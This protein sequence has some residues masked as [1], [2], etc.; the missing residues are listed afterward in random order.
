MSCH[1]KIN[2]IRMNLNSIKQ[3][4]NEVANEKL[5]L[6]ST[7]TA[8]PNARSKQDG[9]NKSD[10]E[11]YKVRYVYT[12]DNFLSQKGETRDFCK[13][14][15]SAKKIYRKEDIIQMTNKIY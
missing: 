3:V 10:N 12:K 15:M 2:E 1:E 13:L 7:G 6:A 9:T 5:E 11:F 4:L 8:R 14:M